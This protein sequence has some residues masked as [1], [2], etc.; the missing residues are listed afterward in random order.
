MEKEEEVATLE[1]PHP[2]AEVEIQVTPLMIHVPSPF[3]YE[4]TRVIP[5][6]YKPIVY[7]QWPEQK[8]RPLV[9]NKSSVTPSLAHEE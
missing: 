5:W 9:I 3:P 8:K 4:R 7:L 2:M 1:I 6:R